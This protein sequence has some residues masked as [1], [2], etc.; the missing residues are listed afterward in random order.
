MLASKGPGLAVL[1]PRSSMDSD[2][3]WRKAKNEL[4]AGD[5]R[6]AG[7]R[8]K[9]LRT[10]TLVQRGQAQPSSGN[11]KQSRRGRQASSA[12]QS[13]S[14]DQ[15]RSCRTDRGTEGPRSARRKENPPRHQALRGLG[16]IRHVKGTGARRKAQDRAKTSTQAAS[17]RHA[18]SVQGQGGQQAL[19]QRTG[20]REV[21]KSQ[22]EPRA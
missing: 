19:H 10:E 9:A 15:G 4:E 5:N 21:P 6:S 20:S 11:W 18:E 22:D 12:W 7:R 2:S 8:G 3:L 17:R 13:P 16:Q 1:G 14:R